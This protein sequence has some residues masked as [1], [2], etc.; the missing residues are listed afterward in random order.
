MDSTN[1]LYLTQGKNIL[2]YLNYE[3]KYVNHICFV[4]YILYKSDKQ[5]S[6]FFKASSMLT[7]ITYFPLRVINF[8]YLSYYIYTQNLLWRP[9]G[10]LQLPHLTHT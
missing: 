9:L 6:I 7:L 3:F 8:T 10:M 1:T 2:V 5:N 4:S